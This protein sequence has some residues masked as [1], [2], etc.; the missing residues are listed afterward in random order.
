MIIT[1][2]LTIIAMI[3]IKQ[4]FVLEGKINRSRK[5]LKKDGYR[6]LFL[7]YCMIYYLAWVIALN[8]FTISLVEFIGGVVIGFVI[9][10]AWCMCVVA[11]NS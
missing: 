6:I 5:E 4:Y 1:T 8:Y 9:V 11:S 10:W 2:I 7:A 3:I